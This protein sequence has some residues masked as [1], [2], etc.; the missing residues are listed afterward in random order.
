MELFLLGGLVCALAVWIK[1]GFSMALLLVGCAIG[2]CGFVSALEGV[3]L[4]EYIGSRIGSFQRAYQ[5]S[6]NKC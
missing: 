3:N 5:K 6:K 4:G 2:V 1:W